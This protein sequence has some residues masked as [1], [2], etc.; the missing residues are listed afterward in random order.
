MSKPAVWSVTDDLK[1]TFFK[2]EMSFLFS[3]KSF[4]SCGLIIWEHNRAA[5]AGRVKI[6]YSLVEIFYLQLHFF[7]SLHEI[8]NLSPKRIRGA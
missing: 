7:E 2:C 8:I 1:W 6:L 3:V 5:L 4:F